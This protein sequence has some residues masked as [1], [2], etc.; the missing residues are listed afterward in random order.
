[1]LDYDV[2]SKQHL[3]ID[4][5][6]A[7]A[8]RASWEEK[9]QLCPHFSLHVSTVVLNKVFRGGSTHQ[10]HCTRNTVNVAASA[11]P[12]LISNV[13][14]AAGEAKFDSTENDEAWDAPAL[15]AV[16]L[17]REWEIFWQDEDVE[18]DGSATDWYEATVEK[19]HSR[20]NAFVVHFGGDLANTAYE[21]ELSRSE[22]RPSV[23]LWKRRSTAL[24]G[25]MRESS[26]E[27]FLEVNLPP[28]TTFKPLLK[29]DDPQASLVPYDLYIMYLD[30]VR[31]SN[32]YGKVLSG[33]VVR[34][35]VLA[36]QLGRLVYASVEQIELKNA[37]SI[38]NDTFSEDDEE[39]DVM[40]FGFLDDIT[41]SLMQILDAGVWL[42]VSAKIM[43]EMRFE[44]ASNLI[45]EN[46][47]TARRYSGSTAVKQDIKQI[48]KACMTGKGKTVSLEA[49]TANEAVGTRNPFAFSKGICT[50]DLIDV[51]KRELVD[52]AL[53]GEES[54]PSIIQNKLRSLISEALH[55]PESLTAS[56]SME[57][58]CSDIMPRTTP[59][60]VK[61]VWT[62]SAA[63]Q[64]S[65]SRVPKHEDTK[66]KVAEAKAKRKIDDAFA[67][68]RQIGKEETLKRKRPINF[69]KPVNNASMLLK[70][71]LVRK[72]EQ[73][74]NGTEC[75][76]ADF[77]AELDEN[78][79]FRERI[80]MNL[81]HAFLKGV[82]TLGIKLDEVTEV[83]CAMKALE[84]EVALGKQFCSEDG[85]ISVAY[86]SQSR[87][88]LSNLKDTKNPTLC[89]RV[90]L[91]KIKLDELV[92][93]SASE[94]AS[95]RVK[96]ERAKA[97]EEVL[98]DVVLTNAPTSGKSGDN[99]G[100][101][102]GEALT[103]KGIGT[104][105]VGQL[106]KSKLA[107]DTKAH[108]I[109]NEDFSS[110]KA[111]VTGL[112]PNP[113]KATKM[114]GANLKS[115][116]TSPDQSA[117]ISN[118]ATEESPTKV[119]QANAP[120]KLSSPDN[121]VKRDTK[122]DV[123]S[124]VDV[125]KLIESSKS[126]QKR[127][128]AEDIPD[129]VVSDFIDCSSDKDYLDN[130]FSPPTVG[131]AQAYD[132]EELNV[133]QKF[134]SDEEDQNDSLGGIPRPIAIHRQGSGGGMGQYTYVVDKDGKK[135]FF[136]AVSDI[137]FGTF[138][139]Y[140]E[141]LLS[142]SY[143]VG[144][145]IPKVSLYTYFLFCSTFELSL[146]V[147]C[148]IIVLIFHSCVCVLL[149]CQRWTK[150]NRLPIKE[151]NKFIDNKVNTFRDTL[152]PM[153][154]VY[155]VRLSQTGRSVEDQEN[156]KKFYKHYEAK[157]R[158]IMFRTGEG[159]TFMFLITPKYVGVTQCLVGASS[160]HSSYA[161][162]LT[163]T[164]L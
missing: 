33:N 128:R 50:A 93:M 15:A 12:S 82:E 126:T 137:R 140:D 80:Q 104:S 153:W 45:S 60:P 121:P 30:V 130:R 152:Q 3:N 37:L 149:M 32:I 64:S 81:R 9:K 27:K 113:T 77:Y 101:K 115:T 16:V 26:V 110:L 36:W 43:R 73:I 114:P 142:S 70:S 146:A 66:E 148:S 5:R 23:K 151:V 54:H 139:V 106:K 83:F 28:T 62:A 53:K 155:C 67:L 51:A 150:S 156:Y 112:P 111:S 105:I 116:T 88:L 42:T 123:N 127:A 145:I 48:V 99:L 49:A 29:D 55:F 96:E 44:K 147:T 159:N 103:T 47:Q 61:Q 157:D 138:L 120:F 69:N 141:A 118:F 107:A 1:M 8:S 132:P 75:R 108:T 56:S 41:K 98:R 24:I 84:L 162:I 89:A 109:Q 25:L 131:L 13:E 164:K 40:V 21:M 85:G 39:A 31:H 86:K 163:T 38:D 19:Y 59:S 134:S 78:A 14:E 158:Q 72:K 71:L 4:R 102:K 143:C 34:P 136:I 125:V 46:D 160:P 74:P 63:V 94:L 87:T 90:L 52:L 35:E 79:T 144:H 68:A 154:E 122:T 17:H 129:R 135:D 65:N 95:K 18:D 22:I 20:S 97:T 133:L 57:K 117:R 124:P 161:L 7:G 92:V 10:L 11:M 91:G 76:S 119:N 6:L 100:V 2:R 58:N